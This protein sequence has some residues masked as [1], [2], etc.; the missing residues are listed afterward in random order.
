MTWTAKN[1][2]SAYTSYWGNTLYERTKGDPGEVAST[3][4]LK[5]SMRYV[6]AQHISV[7]R[8][9][10]EYCLNKMLWPKIARGSAKIAS[11]RKHDITNHYQRIQQ[12]VMVED[13]QLSQLGLPLPKINSKCVGDFV[14]RQEALASEASTKQLTNVICKRNA[15][16]A[17]LPDAEVLPTRMP[18]TDRPHVAVIVT[19]FHWD[20][21]SEVKARF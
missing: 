4:K 2:L 12:R 16:D 8:N 5:F 9:R 15:S 19:T 17:T 14:R 3:Q 7:H 20:Q 10:L 18:E 11:P 13:L 1:F 6:P 21:G